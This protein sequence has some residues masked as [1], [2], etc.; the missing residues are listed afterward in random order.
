MP[1]APP[2]EAPSTRKPSALAKPPNTSPMTPFRYRSIVAICR[3]WGWWGSN[4]R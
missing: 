3:V 2:M 1:K 4:Q